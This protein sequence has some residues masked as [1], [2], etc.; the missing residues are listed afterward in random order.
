MLIANNHPIFEMSSHMQYICD[1]FLKAHDLSYFQ[2]LRCYQD[3]S[4]NMLAN[5]TRILSLFQTVSDKP[6]IYSSFQAGDQQKFAYWFS[7][8]E[9]LPEAPVSL[10]REQFGLYHGVTWVRRQKNYYDMIAF[11]MSSPCEQATGFY[12]NKLPQLE[13]YIDQFDGQYAE[14]LRGMEKTRLHL[15]GHIRD[16]NHDK[17]CLVDGR[18][19]IDTPTGVSYFTTQELNC[20]HMLSKGASHKDI[21]H[22]FAIS[23]RTVETYFQRMKTRT[24][25]Y[26]LSQLLDIFWQHC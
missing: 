18:L 20:L 21:A 14:L 26:S 11:A 4:F 7:W 5:D 19:S 2:Y 16:E 9:A 10:V 13:R 3:G 1:D 12:I 25:A 17:L 15:P 23:T 22:Q 6:L 8:D 24:Q